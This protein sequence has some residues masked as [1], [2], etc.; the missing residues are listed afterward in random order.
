[1]VCGAAG[2]LVALCRV[3]A[4]KRRVLV[5]G[6]RGGTGISCHAG[7]QCGVWCWTRVSGV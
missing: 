5:T 1:V 4:G 7:V 6:S 3:V 2:E